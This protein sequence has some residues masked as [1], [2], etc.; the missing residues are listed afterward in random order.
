M[1]F[2]AMLVVTA[3]LTSVSVCFA[4][5]TYQ[6]CTSTI[7]GN[8]NG[9]AIADGDYIW[10]TGVLTLKGQSSTTPV[11][12][13]VTHGQITFSANNQTYTVKV[14]NSVIAFSPSTTT[15]ATSFT[16]AESPLPENRMEYNS[17]FNGTSW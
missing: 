10:F 2:R 13:Y 8:F 4:S 6:E 7:S 9:T 5:S 12:L 14:P 3:M 16:Q 1:K 11:T 15:A 17:A